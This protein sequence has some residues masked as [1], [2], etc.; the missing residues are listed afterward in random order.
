MAVVSDYERR[1]S[2]QVGSTV[3]MV[4]AN[5]GTAVLVVAIDFAV[6]I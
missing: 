1:V 3:V 2:T 5:L 4:Y 6:Q